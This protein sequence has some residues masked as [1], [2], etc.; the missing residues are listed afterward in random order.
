MKQ[1]IPIAAT[2]TNKAVGYVR[3]STVLQADLGISLEAQRN[4]VGAQAS[5]KD[6]ELVETI[7]DDSSGKSMKRPGLQKVL[8]MV[9]AG[10]VNACIVTKLDR[11]TRRLSDLLWLLETFKAH[12]VT[13]ISIN[14]SLD[15][16]SPVGKLMINLIGSIN[17]FE[18][19]N[20]SVRVAESLAYKASLGGCVGQVPY[21]FAKSGKGKDSALI[22]DPVQQINLARMKALRASGTSYREIGRILGADGIRTS[23]GK[24]FDPAFVCRI[25]AR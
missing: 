13:L 2:T 17:E 9:R 7:T 12:G 20:T 4:K 22:I 10:T 23:A 15:T 1:K 14:E 21:G 5:L 24:P 11:L 6:L 25:L 18:R 16:E 8:A 19:E 3:V